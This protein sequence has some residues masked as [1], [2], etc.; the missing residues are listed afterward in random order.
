M[1]FKLYNADYFSQ[2]NVHRMPFKILR[3]EEKEKDYISEPKT[4]DKLHPRSLPRFMDLTM[5]L[6]WAMR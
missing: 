6:L 1:P 3:Q 5:L 2:T 4:A